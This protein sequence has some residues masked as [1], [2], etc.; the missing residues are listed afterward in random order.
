MKTVLLT[1]SSADNREL[2][3]A[4]SDHGVAVVELPTA[5][6][7]TIA[8]P[9][10]PAGLRAA[11]EGADAVAF[12]SRYGVRGAREIGVSAALSGAKVAVVGPSTRA[13]VERD[14][15][16]PWMVA[17]PATGT[18][19]AAQIAAGLPGGATVLCVQGRHARPELRDGLL[20][21]GLRVQT[22]VVYENR[23]PDPPAPAAI[24]SAAAADAIYL[25]APSAGHRLYGWAPQLRELPWIAIGPTTAAAVV[26]RHG[27]APAGV[28]QSPRLPDVV[29]AILVA[30]DVA[31]AA[32]PTLAS[33]T[34]IAPEDRQ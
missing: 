15:L 9:D 17:E 1:R 10:G 11:I 32:T 8:Q 23:C 31:A 5:E 29:T 20:A 18:A 24:A 26:Q 28:A 33:G 34:R 27:Q 25:A 30:I 4:L 2:R 14:G 22:R 16:D 3:R 12:T 6:L 13:E 7:A 21:R 19:L